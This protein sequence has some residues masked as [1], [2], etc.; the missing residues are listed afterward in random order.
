MTSLRQVE[1][2]SLKAIVRARAAGMGPMPSS[3][4]GWSSMPARVDRATTT[5]VS[6][7]PVVD[8]ARRALSLAAT[9]AAAGAAAVA[10]R[11][12]RSPRPVAGSVPVASVA[13]PGVVTDG[14][15]E[16][17]VTK[18]LRVP[19]MP[20]CAE[21]VGAALVHRPVITGGAVTSGAL[22][23]VGE[24]VPERLAVVVGQVGAEPAHAL[25]SGVSHTRRSS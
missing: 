4:A 14:A 8:A 13:S 6:M 16:S 15:E 17:K 5:R 9:L 25:P 18:V 12:V 11:S 2:C 20:Q 10:S 19:V 1:P 22:G 3:S 23:G 24:A 7:P 21:G